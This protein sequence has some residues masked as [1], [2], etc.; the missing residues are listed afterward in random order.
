MFKLCKFLSKV[1]LIVCGI[2]IGVCIKCGYTHTLNTGIVVSI[3][4]HYTYLCLAGQYI[5]S[6]KNI[7][8]HELHLGDDKPDG[9]PDEV[10]E[11]VQELLSVTECPDKLEPT[12]ACEDYEDEP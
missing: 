2:C 8:I 3:V 12:Q 11:K 6:K 7:H 5:K 10:W 4:L 1:S 9:M